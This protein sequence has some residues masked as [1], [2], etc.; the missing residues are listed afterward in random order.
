MGNKGYGGESTKIWAILNKYKDTFNDLTHISNEESQ[1]W[2][3]S[4][5]K[6]SYRVPRFKD[7]SKGFLKEKDILD[8]SLW[9]A[10][11]TGKSQ[12]YQCCDVTLLSL[13][14]RRQ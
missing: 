13:K 12:I 11:E 8:Q 6:E 4:I 2:L 14:S 7:N 10:P 5:D 3:R 1:D 9:L